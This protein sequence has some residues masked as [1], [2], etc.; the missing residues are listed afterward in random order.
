MP[1]Y[2]RAGGIVPEQPAMTHVGAEPDA[3]TV[4]Q[5][6]SGADGTYRL[7]DDAGEGL[8][9]QHG[10]YAWTPITHTQSGNGDQTLRVGAAQGT[11]PGQPA[12]R[13]FQAQFVDTSKPA[14]VL[15]NSAPLPRAEDGSDATGWWYDADR[16]IVHANLPR[17]HTDQA[18]QVAIEGSHV[19]SPPQQPVVGVDL[20]APDLTVGKQ[21]TVEATVTNHGPGT[22]SDV[23]AT[24]DTP[25]G[26]TVQPAHPS[27]WATSARA[28]RRPRPG[29]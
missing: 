14:Q 1:V 20:T 26:W 29:S 25:S 28:T 16:H 9:Y 21:G 24:L 10:A 11:F 6:Y 15:A 23:A 19:E 3:P 7:Y 27:T 22:A 2:V 13:R 4:L 18:V 5:A 17:T 8:G 12:T